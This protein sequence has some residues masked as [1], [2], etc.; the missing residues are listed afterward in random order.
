MR[1]MNFFGKLIIKILV[2]IIQIPLTILF[3]V[4]SLVGSVAS[5]L[6]WLFEIIIFGVAVILCFFGEFSSTKEMISVFGIAA[7]LF[8]VPN[9]LVNMIGDGILFLK[10]KLSSLTF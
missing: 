10:D 3:F 5:G 2:G 9:F 6:G 4:L 7:A 8:I 1:M